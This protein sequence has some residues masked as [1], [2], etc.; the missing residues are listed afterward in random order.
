MNRVTLAQWQALVS[1]VEQ[2]GFA[3]AAEQLHRSQST[4]SHAVRTL[5]DRLSL[6]AFEIEGRRAVLTEPGRALYRRA[7]R[8][9]RQ[10]ESLEAMA[11]YLGEGWEPEIDIA[12]EAIFPLA[13]V[14]QALSAFEEI[15]TSTR[16]GIHESVLSGTHDLVNSGRVDLALV[17]QVP[18]GFVGEPLMTVDFL[19]VASPDHPLHRLGRELSLDDL[20]EHR[21]LIVRDSG[22]ASLDSGWLAERRWT[23]SSLFASIEAIGQGLGFAW[24]P[25]THIEPMLEA[26]ALKPLPLV[27]GARRRA[28]MHLVVCRPRSAGPATL[29]LAELLRDTCASRPPSA[30]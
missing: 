8:L 7:R 21:H 14:F 5:E 4:V 1:V 19:L 13:L 22:S 10:A 16:I 28:P 2:G 9:L 18:P 24:L 26:G 29:R 25:R 15:C 20:E 23:V 17:A 3:Q 12:V 6:K 27:T 30:T 11:E